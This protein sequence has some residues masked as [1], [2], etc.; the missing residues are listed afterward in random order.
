MSSITCQAMQNTKKLQL[1]ATVSQSR[2][3]VCAALCAALVCGMSDALLARTIEVWPGGARSLHRALESAHDGDEI[4]V[5]AGFYSEGSFVI[6]KAL[7]LR[8]LGEAVI[9]GGDSC[10]IIVVK[11]SS[12]TI[13]G[14]TIQN[15]G[16]SYIHER[17]GIRLEFAHDCLLQNNRILNASYGIYSGKSE[18]NTIRNNYIKSN[19]QSESASG[20]GVHCWYC[21]DYTIENNCIDQHRDGVYLEFTT[22]T[23]VLRN[24]SKNN[25]RYGLHFMFS[26][27]NAYERNHFH[28]NGSG[29]AVMYTHD[30][31]MIGNVFEDNMG[32][33]SYGLL[34]KDISGGTI[35]FNTFRSNT[36]GIYAESGGRLKIHHN[37]FVSNGWAMRLMA[38]STDN[39]ID[40]N[41]FLNNSFDIATNNYSAY[42]SFSGNYWDKYG[43]YDIDKNGIG[44]VPY[45]PVRLFSTIVEQ[46]SPAMLLLHSFF[47]SL[48]DLAESIFPT[49]TPAAMQDCSPAMR[50]L[51]IPS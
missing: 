50:I 8:A 31:E 35:A 37:V 28:H 9:D 15:T 11:A 42:S 39:T 51:Q 20:N 47:V 22:G 6:D 2:F 19:A 45:R 30:I 29:V 17:A 32:D 41:N 18:R 46:N 40:S 38:S 3:V 7:T 34:L 48:L 23:K 10:E 13:D 43:G 5:H 12:V 26:H 49:V 36:A 33:A 24:E 1:L 44:D 27:H 21:Q 4:R 16:N 14:F 25:L